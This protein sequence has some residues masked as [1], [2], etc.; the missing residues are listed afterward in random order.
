[1]YQLKRFG[2]TQGLTFRKT[3]LMLFSK[4]VTLTNLTSAIEF[5]KIKH[6]IL[7][8]QLLQIPIVQMFKYFMPKSTQ[9]INMYNEKGT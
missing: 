5:K 3:I 1:M 8:A 7:C 4:N 2:R 9:R 6:Q